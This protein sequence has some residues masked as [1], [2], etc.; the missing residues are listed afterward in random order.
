MR[1][2]LI[3]DTHSYLGQDVIDQIIDCDEIWH[4]GDIGNIDT[5]EAI[6]A[7]GP[8]VKMVW[9]NIDGRDLRITY[10]KDLIWEVE[11]IKVFMTHIGGYPG[12]YYK[13][14]LRRIQEE[15]PNLF[16][17]GHSHI[18]KVMPDRKNNLLHM[19]PGAC[20]IKGFHKFRTL[21]KFEIINSKIENL[22]AVELGLRG[23]L[24]EK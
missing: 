20:G 23:R 17:C 1:I 8:P 6:E 2:A 3:S 18:L 4:G 13:S 11:G 12:R 21:L 10:P 9:G 22:Q 15:K 16:I 14:P 7:I 24:N 19:N 5:A